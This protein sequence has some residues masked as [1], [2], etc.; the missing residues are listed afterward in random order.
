MAERLTAQMRQ[1]G[2]LKVGQILSVEG[3]TI[4]IG[5]VNALW[6]SDGH[7]T[8]QCWI[9][10]VLAVQVLDLSGGEWTLPDLPKT[11]HGEDYEEEDQRS[12]G[13]LLWHGLVTIGDLV[14]TNDGQTTLIGSIN[15]EGGICD[16]TVDTDLLFDTLQVV[17]IKRL[18]RNPDKDMK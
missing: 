2:D 5:N 11:H 8:D 14:E 1:D 17:R 16:N 3:R 18:W 6:G 4:L 15:L 10:P 12:L 9:K 13:V 7:C